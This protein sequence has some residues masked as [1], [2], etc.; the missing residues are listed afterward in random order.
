MSIR[1]QLRGAAVLCASQSAIYSLATV[2]I[3]AVAARDFPTALLTDAALATLV[4]FVI[5]RV[6][7][8]PASVVPWLGYLVGSLIGTAVG[9]AIS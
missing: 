6:A 5:R 9:M 4:Y 3:R 1:A 7:R 8:E 2:N